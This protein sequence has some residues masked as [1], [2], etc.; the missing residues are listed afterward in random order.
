MPTIARYLL[1]MCVLLGMATSLPAQ[2]RRQST[3]TAPGAAGTQPPAPVTLPD[4]SYDPARPFVGVWQGTF[5]PAS[6]ESVPFVVVIEYVNGGYHG[7]SLMNNQPHPIEHLTDSLAGNAYVWE[8]RNSGGGF[9]VH[10]GRLSNRNRALTGQLSFRDLPFD[11]G[12]GPLPTFTLR[13][14][15]PGQR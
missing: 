4:I 13:R 8:W 15:T 10:T 9:V 2:Q 3:A 5:N 12:P 1:L 14:R 7:Y 11:P 6:G